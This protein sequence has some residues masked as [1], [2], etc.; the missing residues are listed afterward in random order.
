MIEATAP[1]LAAAGAT[2][3]PAPTTAA[4]PVLSS[5]PSA[6][7]KLYLDFNGRVETSWNGRSN[8]TT[9]AFDQDGN[10]NQF[11]S[12]EL[13]AIAEIWAR[14]AEDFAPF[15]LDVTTVDP[16]HQTD[17]VVAIVAIGGHYTDWFNSAAAGVALTGGFFNSNP[18]VG[19]VFSAALGGNVGYVAESVSHEAGHLFGLAHQA[20]WNGASLAQSYDTGD[21]GSAPI[22]GSSYATTRSVWD[23]GPTTQGPN[24][25]QDDMAIIAG[26]SNGFGYR[27]DDFGSSVSAASP[28]LVDGTS[29]NVAGLI[30]RNDDRDVWSIATGGG[31]IAVRM[32]GA[33]PATNL[34]GVLELRNSAGT[35]LAIHDPSQSLD[36]ELTISVGSGTYYLVARSS[37]QY[38]DVGQYR[39][40][41]TLPA[42]VQHYVL[43]DGVVDHR[44]VGNW[45]KVAGKG[46][47][48]DM[49]TA[50]KGNG[51]LI[52]SWTFNRLPAGTYEVW[53]TWVPAKTNAT[54][55]PFIL[56]SDGKLLKTTRV[57][58]KI[59]A[60]GLVADGV[61]WRHLG[62]IAVSGGSA[63]VKLAN[64]ANG[65]VVADAVRLQRV[66][67]TPAPLND[68]P[69]YQNTGGP[70][71][72]GGNANDFGTTPGNDA[73]PE[74][75][76]R[77]LERVDQPVPAWQLSA[78]AFLS[79]KARSSATSTLDDEIFDGQEDWAAAETPIKVDRWVEL[80][81][82]ALRR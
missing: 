36:A 37:G 18:N 5:R 56:R 40:T 13:E 51:S 24:S 67:P 9:P 64:N 11:N 48:G 15:N 43:D 81:A 49:R 62:T 82:R 77:P 22:M 70:D 53:A 65:S 47:A 78:I 79:S 72:P 58:Q 16:G 41:G 14:V 50:G 38:G 69:G 52:S 21:A 60:S 75:P 45:K 1:T 7:A 4:V 19:F 33:G 3:V 17:R 55:A 2:T 27:T 68:M 29:V 42:A 61:G 12:S 8:L 46:F 20:V 35:L 25:L 80:V 28:L 76:E 44:L 66:F 74:T 54:N 23:Q 57:N 34:N 32:T 63:F 30:G 31:T 26:A 71:T 59:A 39:L 6:T 10:P 73:G